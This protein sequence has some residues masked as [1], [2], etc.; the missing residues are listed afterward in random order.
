MHFLQLQSVL[1]EPS[2]MH[3]KGN[4]VQETSSMNWLMDKLIFSFGNFNF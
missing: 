2:V 1:S 3:R 4:L